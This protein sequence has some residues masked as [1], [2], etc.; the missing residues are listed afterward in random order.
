MMKL[1]VPTDFTVKSLQAVRAAMQ[2]F[3]DEQLQ[4]VLLHIMQISND[5][6]DLLMLPR[7]RKYLSLFTEAYRNEVEKIRQQSNGQID[8]IYSDFLYLGIQRV[9]NDYVQ[10]HNVDALLLAEG[11][12]W[13]LPTEYSIHPEKVFVKSTVPVL[14]PS[15]PTA[16]IKTMPQL[17]EKDQQASRYA[18]AFG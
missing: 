17:E 15:L 14:R 9:F 18:V 12:E 16:T 7:E 13:Q 6:M 11:L 5:P 10:R 2:A 8:S 1:I 3:P 4:I